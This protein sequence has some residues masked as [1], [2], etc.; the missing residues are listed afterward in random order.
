[1]A[2]GRNCIEV[3]VVVVVGVGGDGMGGMV[4]DKGLVVVVVR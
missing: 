3:I 1:M 2:S 4:V